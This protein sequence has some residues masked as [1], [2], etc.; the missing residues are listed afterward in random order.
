MEPNSTENTET[1]KIENTE[2]I[3]ETIQETN[4]EIENDAG[5]GAGAG[6]GDNVVSLADNDLL[7][8]LQNIMTW[9]WERSFELDTVLTENGNAVAFVNVMDGK[10]KFMTDKNI[11]VYFNGTKWVYNRDGGVEQKYGRTINSIIEGYMTEIKD[12]KFKVEEAFEKFMNSKA[13]QSK[14]E[15][16]GM[17]AAAIIEM[18]PGMIG[19]IRKWHTSSNNNY[20]F[21]NSLKMASK[22]RS[23]SCLLTDFDYDGYMF[24]CLNGMLDLRTGELLPADPSNMNL[25]S[26]PIA[27]DPTAKCPVF[28]RVILEIMS[29]DSDR[30]DLLQQVFGS[31]M[32]AV[33]KKS[34][35]VFSGSGKNG[36]S[37]LAKIVGDIL[38]EAD[39]N[40]REIGYYS[41]ISPT[42][43]VNNASGQGAT[44][45]KLAV[46]AGV[47]LLVMNEL[48]SDGRSSN[49][50]T[51]S[52]EIV[53]KLVDSPE[54]LKARPIRGEPVTIRPVATLILNTNHLPTLTSFDHGILR[55]L[56][57]ILFKETF[58]GDPVAAG[59]LMASLKGEYQ[60]ILNW[61][62]VGAQKCIKV[63]GG[64]V[65]A[66]V[67]F[68]IPSN[69]QA[70]TDAWTDSDN[71]V[72]DFGAE[73]IDDDPGGKGEVFKHVLA[74]WN[75]WSIE[76]GYKEMG[77]KTL[78]KLLVD[79]GYDVHNR[80]SK[81]V[82]HIDGITF[83]Q[84]ILNDLK[85]WNKTRSNKFTG[86]D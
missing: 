52:D 17:V 29:G 47:R 69:V 61:M 31:A 11:W 65:N 66:E 60:G 37:M 70:D 49:S 57:L 74:V 56:C 40:L 73:C 21:N 76:N 30:V 77:T 6:A 26:S 5:A 39:D 48:A 80:K 14:K 8:D 19:R 75:F 72:I 53:K 25:K 43:V 7:S 4:T 71:K 51:M 45:Y 86:K 84:S 22:L 34:M 67:M 58:D 64:S 50:N 62:L 44:D 85:R 1:I 35:F 32:M 13:S 20:N 27:Y 54:G 9:L 3:Q 33:N 83:S 16:V 38:G 46:I 36:K 15:E 78:K 81:G 28:E 42:V 41:P 10:V 12:I 82:L 2:T 79:A 18:C 55:R 24:G 63:S 68:D 59:K 23:V